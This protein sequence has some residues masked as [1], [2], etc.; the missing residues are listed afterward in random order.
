MITNEQM[1]AVLSNKLNTFQIAGDSNLHGG[2]VNGYVY[3]FLIHANEGEYQAFMANGQR[4]KGTILINGILGDQVSTPLPLKGLGS[5][6]VSQTLSFFIPID[7]SL[8]TGRAEYAKIRIDQFV[9]D[10]AGHSGTLTDEVTGDTYAYVLSV[11]TPFIGQ[12]G[13]Y[14][15]IGFGVP[16]TLNVQWQF[17]L[18]GVLAND[19]TLTLNGDPAS[20]LDGAITRTRV[21]DAVNVDGS[22]EMQTAITQQGLV[23]RIVTPYKRGDVS[24]TLMNDLLNGGLETTYALAY[25]DGVLTWSGT[26]VAKAISVATTAGKG[27]TLTADLV[28]ARMDV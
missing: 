11:S 12:E 14:P 6:L 9:Q 8:T 28:P 7:K 18:D 21:G 26:M 23:W 2:T 25:D 13:A 17:I 1:A 4:K 5:T 22:A 19:I 15:Q 3:D 27:I 10:M 24:Q 20:L 16:A